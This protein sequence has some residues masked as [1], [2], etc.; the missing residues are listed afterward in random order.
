M[1]P[2]LHR[3]VYKFVAIY[4]IGFQALKLKKS[5]LSTFKRAIGQKSDSVFLEGLLTLGDVNLLSASTRNGNFTPF[6]T[7][8]KNFEKK[9]AY[10]GTFSVNLV[11][12]TI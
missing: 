7:N 9:F 10:L 3:V 12:Y 1:Q 8:L 6:K 11:R 5:L 4:Q 2:F